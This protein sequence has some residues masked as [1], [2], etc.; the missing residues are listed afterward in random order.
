MNE[1]DV[2]GEAFRTIQTV[3][4]KLQTDLLKFSSKTNADINGLLIT[5]DE[6][7]PINESKAIQSRRLDRIEDYG[8]ALWQVVGLLH[9]TIEFKTKSELARKV[10]SDRGKPISRQRL[11]AILEKVV[12]EGLAVDPFVRKDEDD[13]S[14]E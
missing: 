7:L 12:K 3:L 2:E 14:K 11:Q 4:L 13:T 9:S 6:V 5:I 1:K 8:A 10:I